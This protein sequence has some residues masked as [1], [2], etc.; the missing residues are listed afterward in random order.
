MKRSL[1]VLA[2]L[3]LTVGFAFGNAGDNDFAVASTQTWYQL[4]VTSQPSGASVYIDG[5]YR[6]RTPYNT[7]LLMGTYTLR[8]EASGYRIYEERFTLD[9]STSKHV[10]L[11]SSTRTHRLTVS[12]YPSRAEVFINGAY[13]GRTPLTINLEEGTHDIRLSLS[14]YWDHWERIRLT[15]DRHLEV[16]LQPE[17]RPMIRSNIWLGSIPLDRFLLLSLGLLF[18]LIALMY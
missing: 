1:F 10:N 2:L 12:S 16:T 13:V 14:G 17:A 18:V 5:V 11:V 3:V 4:S 8:V 6:G 9:K 7:T 15:G